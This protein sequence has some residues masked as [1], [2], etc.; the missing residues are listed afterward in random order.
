LNVFFQ[1]M[2]KW[3]WSIT[4]EKHKVPVGVDTGLPTYTQA[5]KCHL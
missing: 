5:I 2:Y 4:G 3:T 1:S